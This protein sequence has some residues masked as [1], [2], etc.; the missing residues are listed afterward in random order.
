MKLITFRDEDKKQCT[1]N[2]NH[3][4]GVLIPS[5]LDKTTIKCGVFVVGLNIPF[6]LVTKDTAQDILSQM[7]LL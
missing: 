3:I 2:P 6:A 1:L 5:L 7:E 4:I